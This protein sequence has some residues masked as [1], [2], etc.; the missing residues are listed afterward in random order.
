MPG[1]PYNFNPYLANFGHI[2]YIDNKMTSFLTKDHST[3][4]GDD[5]IQ[6]CDFLPSLRR[7][8]YVNVIVMKIESTCCI[9]C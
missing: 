2:N 6:K 1:I 4:T 3:R 7:E 9:V 8:S 5:L